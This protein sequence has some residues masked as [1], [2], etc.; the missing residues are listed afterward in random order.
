MVKGEGAALEQRRLQLF[1]VEAFAVPGGVAVEADGLDVFGGGVAH[2]AVPA[3]LGVA[4]G[5]AAHELVAVGFG[6]YRGSGDGGVGGVAVNNCGVIVETVALEGA[7]LVA[8]DKQEFRPG[9]KAEDGPLHAGDA[10][11]ED[12]EAVDVVNANLFHGPGD[13]L[14]L[15]YGTELF[16]GTLGHLLGVVQQG[17]VKIGR[18]NYRSGENRPGKR[19]PSGLVTAGLKAPSF[20][21]RF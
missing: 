1:Y 16:A 11:P 8:V 10:G 17:V 7:E 19:A 15:D 12:V 3:V 6:E 4:G 5:K 21:I 20:E 14:A 18:K 13:G 2:V 9:I